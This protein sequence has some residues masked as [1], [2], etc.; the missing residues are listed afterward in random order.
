MGLTGHPRAEAAHSLPRAAIA[1]RWKR[2]SQSSGLRESG[3]SPV[4]I[5]TSQLDLAA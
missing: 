2:A 5:R 4:M 1:A 3:Y